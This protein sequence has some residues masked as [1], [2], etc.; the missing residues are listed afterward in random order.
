MDENM[1]PHYTFG[2]ILNKN[3]KR[4][5]LAEA[6]EELLHMHSKALQEPYRKAS[7]QPDTEALLFH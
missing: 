1:S 6:V 2:K 5:S 3:C 4:I 7:R